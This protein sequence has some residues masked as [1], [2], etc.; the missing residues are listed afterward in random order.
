MGPRALAATLAFSGW[1]K[2]KTMSTLGC[3]AR[4]RLIQVRRTESRLARAL[5]EQQAEVTPTK[6]RTLS[7]TPSGCTHGKER[8][9]GLVKE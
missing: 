7:P 3:R 1:D 9:D 6:M 2:K 8:G 4:V 5:G